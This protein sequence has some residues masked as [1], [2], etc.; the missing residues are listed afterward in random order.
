[1]KKGINNNLIN[2]I[3]SQKIKIVNDGLVTICTAPSCKI[4]NWKNQQVFISDFYNQLNKPE[5]IKELFPEFF[6][7]PRVEQ[8]KLKD[9]RGGF[10]GGPTKDGRRNIDSF[11][12][13]SIITLDI[14]NA[15]VRLPELI[16]S[17]CTYNHLI[18]TTIK[19]CNVK[20]RYRCIIPLSRFVNPD[21]HE[22]IARKIA[23]TI[24]INNVD[25]V[26]YKINQIMFFPVCTADGEFFYKIN[27]API[28]NPENILSLY[29]DWTDISQWPRAE[30]ETSEIDKKLKKKKL[31]DPLIKTRI[32]GAFCRT[33][34]IQAGIEKFLSNI[35]TPCKTANRYTYVAGSTAGGLV[36]YENKW[37]YSH[38]GTDLISGKLVNIFDLIRIHLF[39]Q[40]DEGMKPN[41]PIDKHPSFVKMCAFI[42]EDEETKKT[43]G[44]EKLAEA[45]GD[46]KDEEKI[47]KEDSEWLK[48][49][50]VDRKGNYLRTAENVLLILKHD[51]LLADLYAYNQ[52]TEHV[53]FTRTPPWGA[54]N[55]G[56]VTDNDDSALRNHV[57]RVYGIIGPGIIS[58]ALNETIIKNTFHPVREYL[59]SLNWDGVERATTILIKYLGAED[60]PYTRTVTLKTLLAAVSRIFEPGKKFDYMLIIIGPQGA[61][62]SILIKILSRYDAWFCDSLTARE[63]ETVAGAEKMTGHWFLEVGE[64]SSLPKAEVESVKSF[65][66]RTDDKFRVAYG[67][68][69]TSHPRQG[70]LVGTT[71]SSGF[72]RDIT[73]NRRFW[74]VTIDPSN[75]SVFPWD[76]TDYD[77]D[78]IW[79]EVVNYYLLGGEDLFLTGAELAV[80][81]NEQKNALESDEREGLIQE[82]LDHLLPNN[83]ENLDSGTRQLFL[84]GDFGESGEGT[85]RR[86]RVCVAEIWVE[87]Y[88]N[89]LQ[90]FKRSD[91]IE[92]HRIIQ[93]IEGWGRYT[94]GKDGKLWFGKSY[95]G[96][97]AYVRQTFME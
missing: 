26:S 73:G 42:S 49:L 79:A 54:L 53:T 3:V 97:R 43:L 15:S 56:E 25:P 85:K 41:T 64:L 21:E 48:K 14:D 24:G 8:D 44:L 68:R 9:R 34:S 87:C 75:R 57:S 76:L 18:H 31:E 1:L 4:I 51:P 77:V 11:P 50:D 89:Q 71:N 78:Q 69:V 91:Q 28:L 33:Y 39:K 65:I 86:E 37:A 61:G 94:G 83:W 38:H 67:R 22:A 20:P 60:V 32:I 35:Y 29:Y 96:Q 93:K 72:L 46:F 59:Q 55:P 16:Q 63:M 80:A 70:I 95:G 52:F 66:S 88:G 13:R 58:D 62:K 12:E 47:S 90:N 45:I 92:L 10:V 30:R 27:D 23:E 84:S 17:I 7:L 6:A 82:F 2:S 74:P 19:H 5:R 36:I 81:V 40:L